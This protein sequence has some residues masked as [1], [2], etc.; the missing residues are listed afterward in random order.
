MYRRAFLAAVGIAVTAGCSA[1]SDREYGPVSETATDTATATA[2]TAKP[3]TT[4]SV[5]ERPTAADARS[6]VAAHERRY[7]HNELVDA[8][9]AV[10]VE[11]EPASVRVFRETDEGYFLLS[12]CSGSA[13]SSGSGSMSRN[14]SGVVH[15]VGSGVHRR[16]PYNAYACSKSGGATTDRD[17][18]ET[19]PHPARFQ[20][21]DFRS[22]IEYDDPERGGRRVDV[23]V[24]RDSGRTVLDRTYETSLPLTVQPNVVARPGTYVFTAT[25]EDGERVERDWNLA[26]PS[27]PPWWGL[28]AFVTP[29]GGLFAV[30]VDPPGRLGLP[31][32]SLCTR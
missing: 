15:F 23:R 1:D 13:E 8:G 17:D 27:T 4:T 29:S 7:V 10:S 24:E 31:E 22:E 25:L 32:R 28:A 5:P 3:K 9:Y 16:I 21:Y 6:F 26:P 2:A 20:I 14:A 19:H 18:D 12:S 11:V 30:V